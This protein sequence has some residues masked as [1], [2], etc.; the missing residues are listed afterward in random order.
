[1]TVRADGKFHR[2]ERSNPNADSVEIAF[3]RNGRQ[4]CLR[5]ADDPNRQIVMSSRAWQDLVEHVVSGKFDE[6]QSEKDS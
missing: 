6:E 1:V 3:A 5:D 2:V 4:V